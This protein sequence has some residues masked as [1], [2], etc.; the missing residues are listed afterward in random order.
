MS[1][2]R[3]TGKKRSPDGDLGGEPATGCGILKSC[4]AET[5]TERGFQEYGPHS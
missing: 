1:C 4:S 3:E 5:A 2:G